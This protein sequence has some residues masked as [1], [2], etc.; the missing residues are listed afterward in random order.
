MSMQVFIFILT[1]DDILLKSF[2]TCDTFC[3]IFK[4][5]L[6]KPALTLNHEIFIIIEIFITIEIFIILFAKPKNV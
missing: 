3:I 4:V 2:S 6:T 5:E 1:L